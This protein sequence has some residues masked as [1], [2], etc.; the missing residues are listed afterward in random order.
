[1]QDSSSLRF[2]EKICVAVIPVIAIIDA[3]ILAFSGCFTSH[4][5]KLRTGYRKIVRLSEES[6]CKVILLLYSLPLHLHF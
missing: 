2:A 5:K 1:M 6:R 4:T 3:L